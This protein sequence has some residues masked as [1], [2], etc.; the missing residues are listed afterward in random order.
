MVSPGHPYGVVAV[1]PP[2]R[3][4]ASLACMDAVM[5]VVGY[6]NNRNIGWCV[7]PRGLLPK[8]S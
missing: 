5:A 8:L 1:P 2:Y 4:R 7:R 6:V 3:D